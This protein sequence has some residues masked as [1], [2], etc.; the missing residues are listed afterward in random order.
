[1]DRCSNRVPCWQFMIVLEQDGNGI[2]RVH[3]NE[4]LQRDA[5]ELP[6]RLTREMYEAVAARRVQRYKELD[7]LVAQREREHAAV[8]A[9]MEQE[10]EERAVERALATEKAEALANS[11]AELQAQL[12][13]QRAANV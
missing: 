2:A 10:R 1:M 3:W 8:C 13:K 5:P 4:A 12:A 6:K 11:V 9:A 7:D